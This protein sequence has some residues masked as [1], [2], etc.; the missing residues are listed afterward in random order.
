MDA[1]GIA[2]AVA[3]RVDRA[4]PVLHLATHALLALEPHPATG[5]TSGGVVFPHAVVDGVKLV[6]VPDE[7]R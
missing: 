2:E 5:R 6:G 1:H 4:G 3:A 7:P